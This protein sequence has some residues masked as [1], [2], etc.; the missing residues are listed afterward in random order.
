MTAALRMTSC[1]R[2]RFEGDGGSQ[3]FQ[4]L[5]QL[6]RQPLGLQVVQ[7]VGAQLRVG[8]PLRTVAMLA[9]I[10]AARALRYSPLARAAAIAGASRLRRRQGSAQWPGP[11]LPGRP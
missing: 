4:A 10:P 8:R 7:E 9:A 1:S 5:D 2:A 11:R 3:A 6:A